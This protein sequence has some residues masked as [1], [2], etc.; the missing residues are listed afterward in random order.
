MAIRETRTRYGVRYMA[1]YRTTDGSRSPPGPSRPGEKPRRHTQRQ[2]RKCWTESI[3]RPSSRRS[4]PRQ[5]RGASRS[6]HTRK[7]G[8]GGHRSRRLGTRS[9]RPA[10]HPCDMAARQRRTPGGRSAAARAWVS[11]DY[12]DLPRRDQRCRGC[13]CV[14]WPPPTSANVSL[15]TKTRR[16]IG[17]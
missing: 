11:H 16:I 17:K 4:T 9:A 13:R 10:S 7:R 5:S 1:L 14:E 8:S 3:P 2:R 6:R 12:T 15:W